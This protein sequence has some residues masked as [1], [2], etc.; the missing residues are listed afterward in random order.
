MNIR[1]RRSDWT[2]LVGIALVV[3]GGWLL[4]GR[5]FGWIVAPVV[6]V[7]AMI[8]RIG[9]PLLLIAI[10][11]LLVL[12]ARGGGWNPAGGRVFRSRNDRMITG[13][14]GGVAQWLGVNPMPVRVVYALFTLFTGVGL[15]IVLY[16]LG[17]ILLP[18]EPYQ[19][20]IDG[21]ATVSSAPTPPPAPPVPA[22]PAP[23]A[24]QPP[25]GS[26][27]TREAPTPPPVAPSAPAP[28]PAAAPPVPP[29]APQPDSGFEPPAPPEAPAS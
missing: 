4:L 16:V 2:V 25:G 27:V 20:V 11:I 6:V 3:L 23:A 14:L 1:D 15:G 21:N 17:T 24:P 29:A 8:A 19:S 7:L 5:F 10:G 9:W 28:E 12:R 26:F 13:V 22:P 18:E